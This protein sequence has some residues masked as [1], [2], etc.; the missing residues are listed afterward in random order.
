MLKVLVSNIEN[1]ANGQWLSLPSDTEEKLAAFEKLTPR[2]EV[3]TTV[4][5]CITGVES[6]IPNLNR[7]IH[8]HDS[9]EQL[10]ILA[11]RIEKMSDRDAAIFSGAL[12]ME[13]VSGLEDVMRI[14]NSL[15]NYEL[16]PYVTTP[17]ELGVYLVESGE[18]EIHESAWPYLDYER[19]AVEYEANNAGAYTNLGYVVKTGE[20]GEQT[21]AREKQT[22]KFF[23]PLTITSYPS[24]KYG[25]CGAEDLAEELSP[26]EAVNYKDEILAAIQ[27]EK[28]PGEGERG[29][30][31][32]FDEDKALAEKIYSL[33]PTVE[34]W[35]GEL[36]GVMAAEVYGKLT[37]TE[38]AVLTRYCT[39]QMSDGWGEGFEQRPIKVDDGEIYVSF[40]N[41]ENFFIK[42]EYELKQNEASELYNAQTMGGI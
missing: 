10:S 6:S 11:A 15:G 26:S 20:S 21:I 34:E 31:V 18:V 42:P 39:G 23:S 29:L 1:K 17:K 33:H 4:A 16:F 40:W 13:A 9:L 5:I 36:W 24:H 12:D 35:N 41:N 7:Y 37:E 19:V 25:E 38:N 32:Y 27:K 8:E 30:M 2:A 28:L 22:L 3:G 14:A